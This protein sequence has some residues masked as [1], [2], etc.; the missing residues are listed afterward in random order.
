MTPTTT[1]A[2]MAKRRRMNSGAASSTSAASSSTSV[3]SSSTSVASSSTSATSIE[4]REEDQAFKLMRLSMELDKV[5]DK[6]DR[7]LLLLHGFDE[8]YQE[9]IEVLDDGLRSHL[10]Q[11]F[12][13][14]CQN[15]LQALLTNQESLMVRYD[16]AFNTIYDRLDAITA[17]I[18]ERGAPVVAGPVPVAPLVTPVFTDHYPE[19]R[20]D[21]TSLDFS[22][23][24]RELLG[25]IEDVPDNDMAGFDY[26]RVYGYAR[27]LYNELVGRW[28]FRNNRLLSGMTYEEASIVTSLIQNKIL[29][30]FNRNR[31][32]LLRTQRR[33]E[34]ERTGDDSPD[35]DNVREAMIEP[36]ARD[37]VDVRRPLTKKKVDAKKLQVG[38]RRRVKG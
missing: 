23:D 29:W 4:P 19:G 2:A 1:A 10:E 13:H 11:V 5:R 14:C 8:G 25:E 22:R 16:T 36:S 32:L 3:A 7:V 20:I 28:E 24:L 15:Q 26:F 34:E 38:C 18:H 6:M 17:A 12:E 9:R 31:K 37:L 21:P 33:Y 30:K 27:L 35:E